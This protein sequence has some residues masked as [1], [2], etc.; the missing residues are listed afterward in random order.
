MVTSV[1]RGPRGIFGG[2]NE[3]PAQT[4][5]RGAAVAAEIGARAC[6]NRSGG[7]DAGGLRARVLPGVLYVQLPIFN[8][9][10]SGG[11]GGGGGGAVVGLVTVGPGGGQPVVVRTSPA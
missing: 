5:G 6:K 2:R 7:G 10:S 9:F 1:A 3:M 8:T 11:G 4:T